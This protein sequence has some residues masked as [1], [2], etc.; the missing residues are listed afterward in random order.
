[1][2]EF[3]AVLLHPDVRLIARDALATV[4]LIEAGLNLLADFVQVKFAQTVL[5]IQEPK[6]LADHL[7]GGLIQTAF[8][9]TRDQFFQFRRQ[10]Y[11]H[12]VFRSN[13][14]WSLAQIT[15]NV[16]LGYWADGIAAT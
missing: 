11:I 1:M 13:L 8:D 14:G 10:G 16:Q 6:P 7:A 12:T 9:F 2:A 3:H 4:E 15:R 5:V